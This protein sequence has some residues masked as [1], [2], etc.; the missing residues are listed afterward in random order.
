MDRRSRN[1]ATPVR[2]TASLAIGKELQVII[3]RVGMGPIVSCGARVQRCRFIGGGLFAARLEFR[4]PIKL[5]DTARL[6]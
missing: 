4:D 2:F 6:I 3:Y 5:T 1:R